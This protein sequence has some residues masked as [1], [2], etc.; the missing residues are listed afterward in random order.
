VKRFSFIVLAGLLLA[1]CATQP[2]PAP[3]DVQ[4]SFVN[5]SGRPVTI[6]VLGRT[7]RGLDTAQFQGV[8]LPPR[9]LVVQVLSERCAYLYGLP[10]EDLP[11]PQSA[12]AYT[13]LQ[14]ETDLSLYAT[15]SESVIPV[16]DLATTQPRG[17]PLKPAAKACA[18]V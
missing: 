18:E 16:S 3:M 4:L 14:V 17:F 15:R 8:A 10:V 13:T 11:T 9:S 5:D 1:G 7:D 12:K 2:P 6:Q